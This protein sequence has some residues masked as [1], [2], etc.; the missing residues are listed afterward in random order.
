[1]LVLM[2]SVVDHCWVSTTEFARTAMSWKIW[3]ERYMRHHFTL[4]A[5]AF[6]GIKRSCKVSCLL[7]YKLVMS[8]RLAI[9]LIAWDAVVLV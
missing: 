7:M 8:D 4:Y 1:M 3:H 6:G 5:P 9:H 2:V